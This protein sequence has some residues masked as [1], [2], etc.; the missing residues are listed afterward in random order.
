[1][2]YILPLIF[3]YQNANESLKIV[4]AKIRENFPKKSY[5][6]VFTACNISLED[7]EY[8][9]DFK[10]KK[11]GTSAILTNMLGDN[12]LLIQ[13]ENSQDLKENDIVKVLLV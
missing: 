11:K 10:G 9:V 2:L 1:M 7:G 8:F 6:T 5:K 13:D 4:N 3:K 12:G